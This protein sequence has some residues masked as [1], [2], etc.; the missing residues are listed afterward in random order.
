M[1]TE[2]PSIDPRERMADAIRSHEH[3]RAIASLAF[4]VLSRQAE[5]RTLFGGREYVEKRAAEAELTREKAETSL[6]N[7]IA[8][9]ERGP[10]SE[11]ERDL[12]AAFAVAGFGHAFEG[13]AGDAARDAFVRHA[14]WFEASTSFSLYRFVDRLLEREV[15]AAVWKRAGELSAADAEESAQSRA[16]AAARLTALSRSTASSARVALDGV[17]SSAADPA[18]GAIAVALGGRKADDGR[19][20]SV[21]G[22]YRHAPTKAG[23]VAR[24]IFGIAA[25]TWAARG[26]LALVGGKNEVELALA[27]NGLRL[28]G[29]LTLLGRTIR[30]REEIISTAAVQTLTRDRAYPWVHTLA[31]ILSF[32]LGVLAGG[33]FVIDGVRSGETILLLAGAVVVILGVALDLALDV[34]VPGRRGRVAIELAIHPKRRIRIDRI[35]A[36]EAD[37]FVRAVSERVR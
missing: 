31:G 23:R 9:L 27:P 20:P 34:L 24:W 14:D 17:A 5:G 25:I 13:S 22:R 15:A 35:G 4:D 7:A 18:I 11:L 26:I 19:T 36:D 33:F 32:T 2:E 1:A 12:V 21:R 30:E 8:I 28:R 3:A 10:E 6:G 29:R 37:E 16:L